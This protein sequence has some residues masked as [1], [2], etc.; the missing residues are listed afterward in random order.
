MQVQYTGHPIG[1]GRLV[2]RCSRPGTG[3]QLDAHYLRHIAKQSAASQLYQ[4]CGS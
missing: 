2:S 3:V 1:C 4:G